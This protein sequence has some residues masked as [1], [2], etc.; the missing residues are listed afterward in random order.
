MLKPVDPHLMH[1]NYL[2]GTAN[3]FGC[4]N[5]KNPFFIPL[6]NSMLNYDLHNIFKSLL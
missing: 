4:N 2:L 5:G 3:V 1:E 6:Q